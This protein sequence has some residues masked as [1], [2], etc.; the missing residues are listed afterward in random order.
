MTTRLRVLLAA[1]VL[2]YLAGIAANLM[3]DT[4]EAHAN[5]VQALVALS[6]AL[7]LG[8][9]VAW[10][11]PA[12]PVGPALVALAAAPSAAWALEN[13]GVSDA[14]AASVAA[15]V[16][17]GAWVFNLAGFVV[18][19]LVFPDGRPR[20]RFLA[21]L[22]WAYLVAAVAVIALIAVE[23]LGYADRGGPLPGTTPLPWPDPVFRG[24]EVLVGLG[25]LTVLGGA[26]AALVVHY[27]RGDDLVRVQVRWLMLGAGS[28]PVL[29]AAGWIAEFAGASVE[30]VYLGFL[31]A[32]VLFVPATVAVAILRHDLL[33]VDRL[34]GGT[35]AWVVTSVVSAGVFAAV[36]LT[37]ARAG[38]AVAG[39]V[40]A[41]A[42]VTALLLLPL[43]RR[44]HDV[45][46][47]LLDRERTV[48]IAT[49]RQFVRDVRD[50]RAEPEAVQDTLRSALGDRALLV[51][52]RLPGADGY[53]DLSGGAHT[54]PDSDHAITLTARGSEVG[55][56]LLGRATARRRR[57]AREAA[58]EA[59]LPIE[60]SRLR[61]ELRRALADARASRT[62]LAEGVAEERRQLERDLHDGAQQR[63]LAVGM[64]L[65]SAQ[66]RHPPGDPTHA[67]LEAAV[68]ALEE[69]VAELRRLAHGIRPGRLDEG[70]DAAIR[71]LVRDSP[72]PVS[73]DLFQGPAGPGPAG[74]GEAVATTAYFVV[75]ECLSNALKHADASSVTVT[76]ARAGERLTVAVGDDGRGG[77]SGLTALRDRVAAVGGQLEIDSPPDGGT[78]VRAEL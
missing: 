40:T 45:V 70:L 63:V 23:P 4:P 64:R 49:V 53:V 34:L 47:R 42:F 38:A 15:Y 29:L 62:R 39:S 56:V 17:P 51:L 52:L 25:L 68:A 5:V 31:A 6:P 67:D 71:D 10:R 7:V 9:L 22:P 21:V 69:T 3:I 57:R 24:L 72:V 28:V 14:P 75:A 18:L 43:H 37:V 20:G 77:A 60:V 36:V 76:L 8:L 11:R 73:L 46:G 48:M 59:R 16:S 58:V 27:R 33:D 12:S 44:V 55:A 74:L 19:C 61:V 54:I 32:M 41:A 65:R 2:G 35:V 66:R 1:G 50:G 30:V 78:M 13:W 26:V